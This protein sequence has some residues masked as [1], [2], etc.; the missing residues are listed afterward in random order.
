MELAK[1][2]LLLSEQ[3]R[4]QGL[5]QKEIADKL[6]VE[7]ATISLYENGKRGIPLELLDLWLM[8]LGIEIKLNTRG[9]LMRLFRQLITMQKVCHLNR[10]LTFQSLVR[11]V[12]THSG[13]K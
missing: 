5:S 7:Q 3:R 13:K 11:I 9:S 1:I 4:V 2:H 10:E 8:L 6:N 12:I